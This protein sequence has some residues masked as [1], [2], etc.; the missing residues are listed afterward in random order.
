MFPAIPITISRLLSF[1]E[2]RIPGPIE[3]RKLEEETEEEL[4]KAEP[5]FALYIN[6][7]LNPDEFWPQIVSAGSS[8]T[9]SEEE[10]CRIVEERLPHL[11]PDLYSIYRNLVRTTGLLRDYRTDTGVGLHVRY[12][13]EAHAMAKEVNSSLDRLRRRRERGMNMEYAEKPYQ[14]L[15]S[16][17]G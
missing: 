15:P 7:F 1:L 8:I 16:R 6:T 4:R 5:K 3:L 9:L 17:S 11:D 12:L 2:Q 14:I 13:V 10:K